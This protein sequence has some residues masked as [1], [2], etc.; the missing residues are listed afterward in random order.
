MM[1]RVSSSKDQ[2]DFDFDLPVSISIG[3]EISIF[4]VDDAT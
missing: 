1:K 3:F 2:C 4:I